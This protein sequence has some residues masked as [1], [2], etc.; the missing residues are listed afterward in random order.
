MP[1]TTRLL[2]AVTAAAA[3][4]SL[5]ACGGAGSTGGGG[6]TASGSLEVFSWWTSGSEAAALDTLFN[7]FKAKAPDVEV[8]NAVVSVVL[9]AVGIENPPSWASCRAAGRPG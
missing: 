1:R 2:T 7:G 5:T 3:A 6:G 9:R 8:V 4:L